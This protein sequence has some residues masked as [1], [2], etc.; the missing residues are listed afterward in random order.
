MIP[1]QVLRLA[2]R[3]RTVTHPPLENWTA[4]ASIFLAGGLTLVPEAGQGR[5]RRE[6]RKEEEGED[7]GRGRGAAPT[8]LREAQASLSPQMGK[9]DPII[10]LADG[11]IQN[12]NVHA[13]PVDHHGY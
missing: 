2:C 10:D 7:Q 1:S 13:S 4:I 3:R 9:I 12:P 5:R 8:G 11:L 6:E